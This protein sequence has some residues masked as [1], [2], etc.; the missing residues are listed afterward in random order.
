MNSELTHGCQRVDDTPVSVVGC[1]AA[2]D[3]WL[4]NEL[5]QDVGRELH[6]HADTHNNVDGRGRVEP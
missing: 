1:V 5:V 3:L 4:G 2:V 6:R